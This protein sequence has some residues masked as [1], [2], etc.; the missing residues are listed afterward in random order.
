MSS[1]A[2]CAG[3]TARVLSPP[4]R[5]HGG[6]GL[7]LAIVK[8]LVELHGGTVQAQSDGRPGEASTPRGFRPPS[9]NRDSA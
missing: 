4:T 6:L 8:Q 3:R 5:R 1:V 7:G 2:R 9:L